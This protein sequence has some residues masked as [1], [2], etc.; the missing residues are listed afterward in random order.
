[1][2]STAIANTRARITEAIAAKDYDVFRGGKSFL[3]AARQCS[4]STADVEN[5]QQHH[6]SSAYTGSHIVSLNHFRSVAK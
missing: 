5:R 2:H 1:M 6:Q 4:H 3:L